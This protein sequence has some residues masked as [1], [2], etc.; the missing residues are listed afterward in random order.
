MVCS[1]PVRRCLDR[2][3]DAKWA[4]SDILLV[5]FPDHEIFGGCPSSLDMCPCEILNAAIEGM[6]GDLWACKFRSQMES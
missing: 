2:L 1:E 4:N 3:T 6:L 5:R